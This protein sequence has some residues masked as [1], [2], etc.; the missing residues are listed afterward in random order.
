MLEKIPSPH[1]K[2]Q[3]AIINDAYRAD[4]KSLVHTLVNEARLTET[5]VLSIQKRA[6]KLVEQVR[7]E[8]RQSAGIDSFLSEYT[9][10]SEEGIALMCLAEA[11][12]RVP[13]KETIDKLIKDKLAP[14]DWKSHQGQSDMFFVNAATWALMLTG[15]VLNADKQENKLKKALLTFANRAGEGIVRKAVEKAMHI[16]SK[17]FVMGRTI[18]EAISRAK[19]LEA[20]GY[21]YS[22][23]MLGEAA[24]TK[25]DAQKYLLAYQN[26]IENIGQA[27]ADTSLSLYEKAGI[28]IKLSA[29]YPRYQE[30]QYV[31]VMENLAPVLLS[32]AQ[33]AKKHDISMTIDAEESERLDLSLDLI[34]KVFTDESLDGWNGF[35]LALQSYQKGLFTCWIG[36]QI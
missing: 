3:R 25:K 9:L 17:Q 22:Y 5:Q 29:L 35:G 20:E 13:D 14:V 11:L 19:K 32:L 36:W 27:F 8:R 18:Q 10:S 4:E 7:Q 26:A 30:A 31:Q 23:D 28:S 2:G 15:K 24:L 12:L 6:T 16:M 21:R 33:L 1:P 34:E